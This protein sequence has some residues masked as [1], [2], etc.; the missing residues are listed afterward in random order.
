MPS[1]R[2][3]ASSS[4]SLRR[5][6]LRRPAAPAACP[7]ARRRRP[8]SSSAASCCLK[9]SRSKPL[10]FFTFSASCCASSTSTLACAPPRPA[11]GC[12]PC[13]GCARPCARGGRA[14]GRRAS[15][16][17]PANLIGL[18]VTWRTDSAAPPRA[19]PSSLVRTTP[20]SG[21][22]SLNA[23]ATLTASWPCIAS[24]T[25]SVSTGLSAA[26]SAAI[27]L[28]HRSSIA[29]RPAVSTMSTSM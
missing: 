24:T 18:P 7:S 14:R 10:P 12:R 28:H 19:S 15:R 3:T 29:R 11:T 2:G 20:V 22:R 1:M 17:T 4:C 21:R 13:R 23:R 27:S 8:S 16:A 5:V 6:D 26:C 25:N 9:S